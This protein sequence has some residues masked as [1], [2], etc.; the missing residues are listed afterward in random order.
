MTTAFS[1]SSFFNHIK[2]SAS[3]LSVSVVKSE[4]FL[5]LSGKLHLEMSKLT[6]ATCLQQ[7]TSG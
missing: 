4:E 3:A 2:H 5:A 6:Q 7:L 1:S